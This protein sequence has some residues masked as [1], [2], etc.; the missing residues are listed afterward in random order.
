MLSS[1]KAVDCEVVNGSA[2]EMEE[3]GEEH[4]QLRVEKG[5]GVSGE[6]AVQ[7]DTPPTEEPSSPSASQLLSWR[8][9]LLLIMAVTV[10]NFPEVLFIIYALKVKFLLLLFELKPSNT[11]Y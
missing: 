3:E 8:R 10:H 4:L 6:G 1:G 5:E 11:L 2:R 7:V 9:I